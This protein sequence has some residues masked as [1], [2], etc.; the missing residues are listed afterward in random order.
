[1]SGMAAFQ[2]MEVAVTVEATAA[3]AMTAA[4]ATTTTVERKAAGGRSRL[5]VKEVESLGLQHQS[6][7][8][9]IMTWDTSQLSAHSMPARG[10]RT[11]GMRLLLVLRLQLL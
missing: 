2:M 1:M 5:V 9:T 6:P 3:T 10:V 4:A 7:V 8:S 11:V